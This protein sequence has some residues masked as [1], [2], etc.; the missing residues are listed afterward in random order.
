MTKYQTVKWQYDKSKTEYENF[1][2]WFRC[3]NDERFNF[4][5]EPL[6]RHEAQKQYE[7]LMGFKLPFEEGFND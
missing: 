3:A 1:E 7:N 5:Q 2:E 6:L 4:D